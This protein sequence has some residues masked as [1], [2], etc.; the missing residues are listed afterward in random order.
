MQKKE[1]IEEYAKKR[2][3]RRKKM[4]VVKMNYCI[5]CQRKINNPLSVHIYIHHKF[6]PGV[7]C[8]NGIWSFIELIEK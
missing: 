7:I 3:N 8:K 2:R 5:R 6:D 1:G 4:K